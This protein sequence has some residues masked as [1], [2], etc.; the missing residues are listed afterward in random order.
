MTG[1]EFETLMEVLSR[2]N[3]ITTEEGAQ[4][5]AAM[6]SEQAE[7]NA[8]FQVGQRVLCHTYVCV[9]M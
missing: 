6:I 8:D 2:L 5:V 1:E 4:N 3:Y 7:L 9:I